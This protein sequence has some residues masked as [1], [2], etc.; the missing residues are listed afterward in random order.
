[1]RKVFR[2]APNQSVWLVVGLLGLPVLLVGL[3][4]FGHFFIVCSVARWFAGLLGWLLHYWFGCLPVGWL[5]LLAGCRFGWFGWLGCL[6]VARFAG[7]RHSLSLLAGCFV[8]VSFARLLLLL[9]VLLGSV[10]IGSRLSLSVSSVWLLR[11][12]III[13]V[14]HW[15]FV[16]CLV[17]VIIV[18]VG[19]YCSLLRF[20]VIVVW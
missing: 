14:R 17:A 19:W 20:V 1:L 4:V 6:L 15:L 3:V 10:V 2:K 16:S 7:C 8:A 9:P 11:R 18:I 13:T 12:L 5:A